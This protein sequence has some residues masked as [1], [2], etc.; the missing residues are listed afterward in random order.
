[1]TQQ[2]TSEQAHSKPPTYSEV[3][4]YLEYL[5]FTQARVCTYEMY[6]YIS[7]CKLCPF[8]IISGDFIQSC[9]FLKTNT[10]GLIHT[11]KSK[12]PELFI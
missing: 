7:G 12:H 1:M 9:K 2:N 8:I 10:N 3:F 11:L 6:T 4:P 5:D